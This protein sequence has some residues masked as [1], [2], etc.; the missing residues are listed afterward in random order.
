MHIP[1]PGNV[2]GFGIWRDMEGRSLSARGSEAGEIRVARIVRRGHRERITPAAR[3]ADMAHTNL[4]AQCGLC[5][6]EVGRGDT[7]DA[8]Q[9][10]GPRKI[11]RA[12]ERRAKLPFTLA[13]RDR[14]AAR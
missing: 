8:S 4:R 6:C 5:A 9:R 7:N 3:H 13:Y 11:K 10:A 12:H 14:R 1:L 2:C